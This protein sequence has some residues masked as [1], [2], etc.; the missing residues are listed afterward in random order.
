MA[1]LL[2]FITLPKDR[3]KITVCT[4]CGTEENG[5]SLMAQLILHLYF[6]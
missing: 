2:W 1:L 5:G 4:P 6:R 3:D